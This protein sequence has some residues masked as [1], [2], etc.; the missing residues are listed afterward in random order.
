M[1]GVASLGGEGDEGVAEGEGRPHCFLDPGIEVE[2]R[3]ETVQHRTVHAGLRPAAHF[4]PVVA[5]QLELGPGR[6]LDLGHG[7]EVVEPG[8]AG[9]LLQQEPAHL[10]HRGRL[11]QPGEER[12][13]LAGAGSLERLEPGDEAVCRGGEVGEPG[14]GL[15]PG[16]FDELALD[17]HHL[18]IMAEVVAPGRTRRG[19]GEPAVVP[20]RQPTMKTRRV[21]WL[22]G[23]ERGWT[24]WRHE[25]L[26]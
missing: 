14:R 16:A 8:F 26:L 25:R 17:Q 11:G 3:S 20:V 7:D 22:G 2:R 13:R 21:R 4:V 9:H 1:V 24:L 23:G 10:L 19:R 5:R 18:R 6:H 12:V 15:G